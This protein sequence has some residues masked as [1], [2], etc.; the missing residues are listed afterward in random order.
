MGD[1]VSDFY[2]VAII[3]GGHAGLEA[4]C[5]AARVCKANTKSGK[6]NKVVLI[7]LK[8]EN[9]GEMSC[10]PA[11]G[12][13]GKGTIVREI[14]AMDGLMG[15]AADMAGIHF[16]IL[17]QK[18]GP[19][20]WGFR[21]QADRKLYKKAAQKI[22]AEYDNID[23]IFESCEDLRMEGETKQ[24]VLQSGKI[25]NCAA[26]V[27]TT[28]TFLAGKI[29][30]GEDEI[31]AGR[32]G[33]QPSNGL[34][35]T[36]KRYGFDIGRL[37]TGT[38][39]RLDKNTINW[40]V[41][42]KQHGDINPT[43]FSYLHQKLHQ[44]ISGPAAALSLATAALKDDS[45]NTDISCEIQDG[46]IDRELAQN[47]YANG[48][49]F[50]KQVPCYISH[51]NYRT[52]DVILANKHRSPVFKGVVSTLGP[53]YCP[54]IEDKTRRFENDSH[55][56]FLEPEGLDSNLIY[57]NGLSTSM[58]ED[59]QDAFMA[60]L[61]GCENVKI[62]QY[63]YVIEYDFI[64]PI[65]LKH[66]LETK[67]V[68]GLFLAGQINGT[69]GYEE[70]GGQG[71]IAGI[72]AG[73]KACKSGKTFTIGRD[74]SYVGVMIDDL[75][76][77]GIKEP[78]RMFTSRSEY[79]L[80]IRA[81]NA[82]TRMTPK[83]IELNIC[84]QKRMEVF[85][86]KQQQIAKL[87]AILQSYIFSPN[88]INT[89]DPTLTVSFDGTKRNGF[90]LLSNKN[91]NL[92]IVEKLIS[93]REPQG[94][95]LFDGFSEEVKFAVSTEAKYFNYLDRQKQDIDFLQKEGSI[96]IPSNLDYTQI[97]SISNEIK[98][99]LKRTNPTKISDLYQIQGI[100]PASIIALIIFLKEHFK[101]NLTNNK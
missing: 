17:N 43:P 4:L 93:F 53:R 45:E 19:A 27:L 48:F 74:E 70:A 21:C 72:N 15:R 8:P 81:D 18:K 13:I 67:K 57:P 41:L 86:Y 75:I 79:R 77:K 44:K 61:D 9:I 46:D 5:A 55:R 29:L 50:N 2:N 40:S 31:P 58:P 22:L 16:K 3:G 10:N 42:P 30:R 71:L 90:E 28:G 69:T 12:G 49:V 87:K 59:V 34:S 38:P 20:V 26:V 56:V 36:L 39:T 14:D 52:K 98:D 92:A 47:Q 6:S 100:T 62:L 37:K 97:K 63:G 7:T 84:S 82:D 76:F 1:V 33:E 101:I 65:E 85:L 91:Y 66:T 88:E 89:I 51:T 83:A 64:N 96:A 73:L 80:S 95:N 25:I 32:L 54:S 24:I 94:T 99:I 11:F 68:D 78:Y 35:H 60:T 23:Y